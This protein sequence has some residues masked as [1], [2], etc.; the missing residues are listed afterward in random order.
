M[1][2]HDWMDAETLRRLTGRLAAIEDGA[3]KFV[4]EGGALATARLLDAI[5]QVPCE[6]DAFM[7]AVVAFAEIGLLH[8]VRLHLSA[9][10]HAPRPAPQ[11]SVN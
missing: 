3:V 2:D 4:A 7:Q 11:P 9:D 10:R 5:R 6:G 8:A 1:P